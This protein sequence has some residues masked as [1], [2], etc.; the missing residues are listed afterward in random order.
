[1][2]LKYWLREASL[3]THVEIEGNIRI[4]TYN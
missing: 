3:M 2:E 1:L 4:I